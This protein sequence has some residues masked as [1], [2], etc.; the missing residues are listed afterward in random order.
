MDHVKKLL[1]GLLELMG[2]GIGVRND[3]II[4]G[5]KILVGPASEI[6]NNQFRQFGV[7][8]L[9]RHGVNEAGVAQFLRR[10]GLGLVKTIQKHE[11][12]R[13]SPLEANPGEDLEHGLQGSFAKGGH[14]IRMYIS[15]GLFSSR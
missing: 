15:R 10:E 2:H 5:N 8:S 3:L 9:F 11:L 4:G 13:Q 7:D 1:W 6:I 12:C 14:C